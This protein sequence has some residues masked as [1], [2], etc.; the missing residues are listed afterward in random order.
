MISAITLVS[1]ACT[2]ANPGS[3][4]TSGLEAQINAEDGAKIQAIIDSG[5]C[6]PQNME[7]LLQDTRTRIE[8][9]DLKTEISMQH[10]A[11]SEGC[12]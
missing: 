9:G 6:L 3:V 11:P 1:L 2:I 4:N 10:P 5:A 12:S 7:K 8:S